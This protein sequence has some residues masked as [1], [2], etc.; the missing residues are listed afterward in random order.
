MNPMELIHIRL[1]SKQLIDKKFRQSQPNYHPFDY[2]ESEHSVKASWHKQKET[3]PS[4]WQPFSQRRQRELNRENSR[5]YRLRYGSKSELQ[6]QRE[7]QLDRTRRAISA[8]PTSRKSYGHQSHPDP[9]S[10]S[11]RICWLRSLST[12]INLRQHEKGRT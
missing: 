8:A 5:V 2:R 11:I 12:I 9:E 6:G 1:Q 10:Q 3:K 7:E 4:L